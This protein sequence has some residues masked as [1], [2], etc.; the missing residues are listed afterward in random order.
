MRILVWGINYSP[1]LTGIAPFNAGLCGHLRA[2]GHEVEMVTSFAYY[3]SWTKASAD[4]GQVYRRDELAGIPVYRCWHYVPRR[5]TTVARILH[6]LTFGLVSWL[7]VLARPAPDLYVVISPPLVLGP[8]ASL[9][10]WLRRRPYV[11]HVQDLQPDAAVGLGMVRPG[12]MTRVLYLLESWSY[13]HAAAVSGISAGMLRAFA[14]KGVP[15]TRRWLFPNWTR[16]GA[17]RIDP[18]AR[19][20]AAEDFRSR[21]GIPPGAFV[22]SYSGNLGRKQGLEMLVEAAAQLERGPAVDREIVLLI[23]GDGAMREEL[24]AQVARLAS[25]RLR[26]LPLQEEDGYRGLLAASNVSLILQAPGTGQ[27]FFPSKLLTVLD[28]GGAV[29]SVAD[30]DSELALAVA[31]GGFGWNVQPGR[32]D[33][34][35]RALRGLS[36]DPA[37]VAKLEGATGWVARFAPERV[38]GDF[39]RRL[40]GLADSVGLQ[41]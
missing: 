37:E 31:E 2:C 26:L 12:V 30:A 41:K 5:V 36:G 18:A 25:P 35:V 10:G 21:H 32:P 11:F 6:E 14:R 27:Y 29:L 1:E 4:R 38:L 19:R 15:E 13:R 24:S 23:V 33:L 40:A 22:A 20:R 7:R 9:V 3:P 34:L 16:S 39:E 28:Q 17:R 8:L